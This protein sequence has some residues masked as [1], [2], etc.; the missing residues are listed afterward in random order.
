LC[1]TRHLRRISVYHGALM[2]DPAIGPPER[3]S[4]PPRGQH[5]SRAR[6]PEGLRRDG[7]EP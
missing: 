4:T 3:S 2:F 5:R 7:F 1:V 6:L